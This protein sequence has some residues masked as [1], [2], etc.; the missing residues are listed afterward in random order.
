MVSIF[1][2]CFQS[3]ATFQMGFECSES[4]T[5]GTLFPDGRHPELVVAL[6]W[7]EWGRVK[8]SGLD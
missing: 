3:A 4:E 2:P 7:G 8:M 6:Y 1:S 5:L